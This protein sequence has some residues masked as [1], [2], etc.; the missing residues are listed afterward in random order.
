MLNIPLSC[1]DQ[2]EVVKWYHEC[3]RPESEEEKAPV[4]ATLT[5]YP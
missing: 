2:F 5:A 1:R 3:T 4:V